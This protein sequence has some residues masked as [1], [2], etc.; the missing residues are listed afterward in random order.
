MP[1]GHD[2]DLPAIGSGFADFKFRIC[3][4]LDVL[5]APPE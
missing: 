1:N 5:G 3:R 4:E 2:P